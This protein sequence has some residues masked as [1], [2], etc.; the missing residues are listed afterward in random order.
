MS[1]F[2]DLLRLAAFTGL[3]AAATPAAAQGD[4][5]AGEQAFR[6]CSACHAVGPGAANRVGP[7][8]NDLIG[9]TAGSAEGFR[10]SPALTTAGEEGLVWGPD[11]LDAFLANPRGNIPGNRMAYAGMRDDAMRG[12]VIAYLA[13]FSEPAADDAAA[14]PAEV[15]PA[16]EVAAAPSTPETAPATQAE[17]TPAE[18]PVSAGGMHGTFGLGRLATETEIAA[19]DIDVRPDGHGLPEGRGTVLDG[20]E[21][22]IAQC[23]FCH[24]DFGEAVDRWPVLAGGQGTLD[25]ESP[26]KTIGSYWPYLST[27]FDYVRRAMPY[28][29]AR[30]LSDDD[31]YALTAYLLYLNDVVLD[32][33][34][35]LSNENFL[36]VRLPNEANFIDDDRYEEPHYVRPTEVCMSGCIEGDAEI[37]MRAAVVD[38]TPEGPEGGAGID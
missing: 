7:Q 38:V 32:E 33:E 35:E 5:A 9:R 27:V 12:N 20:E 24:G 16:P 22:Y 13:S 29:N 37:V 6:Q 3:V 19:W 11:T 4:I 1:R 18:A 21:I 36:D 10:Y 8:L 25:H 15:T 17:A 26:E 23:A 31:V 30:S 14:E 2:P 28:G 34:F